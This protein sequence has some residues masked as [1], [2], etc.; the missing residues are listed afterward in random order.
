MQLS[1][2]KCNDEAERGG[3]T[4]S[5]PTPLAKA[6]TGCAIYTPSVREALADM[7]QD[8]GNVSQGRHRWGAATG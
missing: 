2:R 7:E 5:S 3:R 8:V 1:R 6:F 4:L